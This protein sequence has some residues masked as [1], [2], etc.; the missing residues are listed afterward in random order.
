[1]LKAL[2]AQ[3]CDEAGVDRVLVLLDQV[4]DDVQNLLEGRKI[5]QRF[6]KGDYN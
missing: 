3:S 2:P 6:S 5:C 1:M 4:C